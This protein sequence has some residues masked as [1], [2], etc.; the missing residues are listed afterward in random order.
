MHA[1]IKIPDLYIAVITVCSLQSELVNITGTYDFK[2]Y[3]TFHVPLDDNTLALQHLDVQQTPLVTTYKLLSVLYTVA[4]IAC[5]TYIIK[6]RM[7]KFALFCVSSFVM[8]KTISMY[9]SLVYLI[10]YSKNGLAFNALS[11]TSSCFVQLVDACLALLLASI[12]YSWDS[13]FREARV[14]SL[15]SFVVLGVML[16]V[17]SLVHAV[18]D[19]SD[20]PENRMCL[21]AGL[22]FNIFKSVFLFSSILA[23]NYNG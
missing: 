1:L 4:L 12:S 7:L 2:T 14:R 22:S 6:T 15:R 17:L 11:I 5:I 21:I 10:E 8:L 18:C 16:V 3:P 20:D 13:H 23:M 19:A 9:L